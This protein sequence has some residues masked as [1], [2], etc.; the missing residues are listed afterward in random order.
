MAADHRANRRRLR[1]HVHMPA[2]V[3]HLGGWMEEARPDLLERL[4]AELDSADDEHPDVSI[5]DESGW[6]LSAFSSGLLV[7]ENVE[8]DD[9]P[10]HMKA[11]PRS[12]MLQHFHTLLAGDLDRLHQLPWSPGYG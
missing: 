10:Q 2:H 9:E 12:T 11:V 5:G 4:L 6:T 7:W 1:H 3:T 8:E